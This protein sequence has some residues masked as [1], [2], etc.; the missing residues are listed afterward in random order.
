MPRVSRSEFADLEGVNRASVT[1]WIRDR[2][3]SPP[4]PDGLLDLD[5][6]RRE[7][8]ATESPAARDQARKAQIDAEKAARGRTRTPGPRA[9]RAAPA[10]PPAATE[11]H[12]A[13]VT[14]PVAAPAIDLDM[15]QVERLGLGL[16]LETYKLQKAKAE[17]ANLELDQRAG[18]LVERAEVDFVLSDFGSTV[19]G[20]LEAMPKRLAPLVSG[21]QGDAASLEKLFEDF[22]RETLDQIT[23]HLARCAHNLEEPAA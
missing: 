5:Q 9:H 13:P 18:L 15:G 2:R 23:A 17:M 11:R 10:D 3:I 6:A 8:Q 1:R 7:R 4:G 14:A 20:Y 12:P 19:R 16:K 21:H 22:A